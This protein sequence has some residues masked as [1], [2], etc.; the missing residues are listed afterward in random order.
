MGRWEINQDKLGIHIFSSNSEN[1]NLEYVFCIIL[2]KFNIA[3]N[4][5]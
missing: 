1:E 5:K 4:L 3:L 2:N